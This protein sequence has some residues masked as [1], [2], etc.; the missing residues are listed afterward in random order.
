[1]SI[2]LLTDPADSS[3]KNWAV[4]LGPA[5]PVDAHT[6]RSSLL[7][8]AESPDV[9]MVIL[10][11]R[12]C[13][14]PEQLIPEIKAVNGGIHILLYTCNE[15]EDEGIRSSAGAHLF[16]VGA[17][18]DLTGMRTTIENIRKINR[19]DRDKNDA[20][21]WTQ[22]FLDNAI[23]LIQSVDPTGKLTYTNKTWRDVMGYTAGEV[24]NLNLKDII[25]P[26]CLP[27]CMVKF[28]EVMSGKDP[29]V[30]EASFVSKDGRTVFVEGRV[31][32]RFIGNQPGYTRGI[33]RDVT[34]K[35]MAEEGLLLANRKLNL[36]NGII[37]HDIL[38]QL[39]VLSGCLDL[40]S[41]AEPSIAGKGYLGMEK[42][43][44]SNIHRLISFTK[45]YQ[46]IGVV[47][48]V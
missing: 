32:C 13:S 24:Q 3:S 37:R 30:L 42:S 48:P 41:R 45:T 26:N 17:G 4:R 31:N 1:M 21:L 9:E 39:M 8:A 6:D 15:P 25:E 27:K 35:K 38:N 46:D 10:D 40:S 14:S 11:R 7:K 18:D 23:V 28:G 47:A 29:G 34:A 36:M 2:L 20:D 19:L 43:A 44:V 12:S 5:C 16:E 33:F 22:D